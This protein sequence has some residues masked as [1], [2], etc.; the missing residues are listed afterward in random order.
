MS[1][2][3]DHPMR[4][5]TVY[6]AVCVAGLLAMLAVV[7]WPA[8]PSDE[9][10]VTTERR[11]V[12]HGRPML[13]ETRVHA[14]GWPE[15]PSV[16]ELADA[17]EV[18]RAEMEPPVVTATTAPPPSPATTVPPPA[19][20]P[21]VPH[22]DLETLICSYPWDCSTA[23]RVAQCESTMNPRAISPGGHD[24]GLMQVN[25]VHRGRV[26]DMGYQWED[27]LDPRVNLEVA[28]TIYAERGNW[29]A[30]VCAR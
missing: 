30:W 1:A 12:P 2:A 13:A 10:E 21:T 20:A 8:G 5:P 26:A 14:A 17:A 6:V 27:L 7:A 19:P 16:A 24:W 9:L 15:W 23:L 11:V 4:L 28:W 29:S 18:E 3:T 25:T 22:G